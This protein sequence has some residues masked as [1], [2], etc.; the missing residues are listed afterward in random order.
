MQLATTL[1]TPTLRAIPVKL[2]QF[3]ENAE[4]LSGS[5]V[6]GGGVTLDGLQS[7]RDELLNTQIQQQTSLA[8]QR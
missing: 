7:V 2:P 6:S 3:S 4:T 5:M 1:P 8:E